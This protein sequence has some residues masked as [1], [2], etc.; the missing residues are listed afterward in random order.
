MT[1]VSSGSGSVHSRPPVIRPGRPNVRTTFQLSA[2]LLP[3][4]GQTVDDLFA[5]ARSAT[6]DWLQDK[7]S[8]RLSEGA[9]AGESF[10]IDIHGQSI[11]AVSLVSRGLWTVRL[12]QPDAPFGK[13]RA[14]P[15]RSWTTEIAFVKEDGRVRFGIRVLCASLRFANEP[16]ALTRPRIVVELSN[17]FHMRIAATVAGSA[18]EPQDEAD[19]DRLYEVLTDPRRELPV[20]LLSVPDQK[21]LGYGSAPYLLDHERLAQKCQGIAHVVT[22]PWTLGFAWTNKVG[23]PWSAFLGAVRTYRPGLNFDEDSP[24]D[25]PRAYAERVLEFYY[26]GEKM[27]RAF[28]HFLVDRAYEHAASKRVDWGSLRFLA[29][30]RLAAAELARETT[31]GESEWKELYEAEIRSLKEKVDELEGESEG[32]FDLA[33]GAERERDQALEENRLLR[34]QIDSLR[35]ALQAK[36]GEDPDATIQPPET[37]DELPDWVGE[38]LA[39]RLVLHN[40]AI[41]NGLKKPEFEDLELVARVLLLLASEYRN[42]RMGH[43]GAKD[44]FDA[45]VSEMTLRYDGSISKE[46]AGQEGETYFVKWPHSTSSKCFLEHH[47]RSGGNTRDPKRCLA[48]YFFWDDDTQQVVVGWLPSHLNNRLT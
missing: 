20:Y 41:N 19:L 7:F 25:H 2:D 10:E 31:T 6:L 15:G 12:V 35:S 24:S 34:V 26:N 48:V 8:E 40:R 22:M 17:R 36:T 27:E 14:V 21:Q 33:A 9:L 18:W 5:S 1:T 47:I 38:N 46:R 11:A 23:K 45:K 28:E 30:A 32:Y 16:I 43:P 42:M 44:A 4:E 3:D 37:Y 29:D 39:G 13:R